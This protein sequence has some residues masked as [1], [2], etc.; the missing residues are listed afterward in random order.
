MAPEPPLLRSRLAPTPSG[1]LHLGNACNFLL[2]WALVRSRGGHLWLRVDDLDVPR[3]KP[4]FLESL[5]QDLDWLGLDW[6]SGPEGPENVRET[7]SQR[8]RRD[9]YEA[10]LSQLQEQENLFA[11]ICSRKEVQVASSD[12]RYP[13]TCRD[14]GLDFFAPETAWRLRMPDDASVIMRGWPDS[15]VF[16]NAAPAGDLVLRRRDGIPAYQIAS[17]VDDVDHGINFIVRG[18]DLRES[19]AIQLHL[20]ERLEA[21]SFLQIRFLHHLLLTRPDG[22][23]LSKSK[24]DT[25]LKS[26]RESGC[27][28][29]SVYVQFARWLDLPEA[30][31]TTL[32][33]LQEAL[34]GSPAWKP[35]LPN[36]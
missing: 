5:F 7:W 22:A 17:L 10:A 28:V 30:C 16:A 23:K 1:H 6:D 20:A 3:A 25:T 4:E 15:E 11:C 29:Q 9:R 34:G 2:T 36:W 32:A 21:E 35:R 14:C 19:S 31:G 8:L 27:P 13:G 12:G 33:G 24:G 26:M 18:E